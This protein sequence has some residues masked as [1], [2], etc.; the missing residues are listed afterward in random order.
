[1]PKIKTYWNFIQSNT[2]MV[3]KKVFGI[4]KGQWRI[5]LKILD[6]SLQNIP[7]V[8]TNCICVHNLCIIHGD[9]FDMKWTQK[10]D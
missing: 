5:L 10:V 1:L 2:R 9:S 4:L 8:I 7:E 3:L 6:M